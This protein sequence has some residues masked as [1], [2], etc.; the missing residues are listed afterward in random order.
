MNEDLLSGGGARGGADADVSERALL[1]PAVAGLATAVTPL[2]CGACSGKYDMKE[3]HMAA[4]RPSDL[5]L[6]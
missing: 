4:K 6:R 2:N 1:R 3:I 5:V